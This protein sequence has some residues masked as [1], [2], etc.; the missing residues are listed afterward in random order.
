M[1]LKYE[2]WKDRYDRMFALWSE[3]LTDFSKESQYTIQNVLNNIDPIVLSG[4]VKTDHGHLEFQNR[5]D[6]IANTTLGI[7]GLG[8]TIGT[9]ALLLTGSA[10][11][12]SAISVVVTNPVGWVI[13]G[14]IGVS[15]LWKMISDP[16]KRKREMVQN[17]TKRLREDL[18]IIFGDPLIQHQ[19]KVNEVAEQFF[20]T[21]SNYYAPLAR[22][23]RL[24]VLQARL[25]VKV[26]LRIKEDIHTIFL[27]CA[28]T[29][30]ANDSICID[31]IG[32]FAK[33]SYNKVLS[34][35]SRPKAN[36]SK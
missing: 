8:A 31:N 32:Q 22:D 6:H 24:A 9:V 21:A 3:E 11:A 20:S 17:K 26:I 19:S 15:L 28:K 4:L 18:K 27:N 23:A 13:G 33:T 12:I 5:L 29:T 14:V 30:A 10:S 2:R 36:K 1:L 35:I 25:Q 16:E 7:A 34:F